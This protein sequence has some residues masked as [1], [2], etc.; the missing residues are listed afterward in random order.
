VDKLVK[1]FYTLYTSED[2]GEDGA[3]G[4]VP[5]LYGFRKV[6]PYIHAFRFHLPDQLRRCAEFGI[7]LRSLCCQVRRL[8][9][10]QLPF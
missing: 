3:P 2:D 10:A 5:G 1:A 6:T 9:S 4:Y 8:F 7:T